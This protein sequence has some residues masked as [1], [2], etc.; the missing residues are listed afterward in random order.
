MRLHY[1]VIVRRSETRGSLLGLLGVLAFSLTLPATRAAVADLDGTIVGLGRALVAG[2]LA[3]MLLAIK[4][5]PFPARRQVRS[6]L[7]VAL[8]VVV[9]FPLLSALA[10]V[11]VPSTHGAIFV[12]LLPLSTAIMAVVRG[13]ERPTPAFWAVALVGIAIVVAFGISIGGGQLQAADLLLLGAIVAAGIGYAEG[14]RLAREMGGWRVVSWALVLAAPALVVPVGLA[15]REHGLDAAAP[16]WIGFAYVSGV[17]MFLA[18]FVWFQGLAEA[19]IARVGQ[20][21]LVQP[22]L[23]LGWAALL[24]GEQISMATLAAALGV[25]VTV[26]VGRRTRVE[27]QRTGRDA[28]RS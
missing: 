8:G 15:I 7:V 20:L 19:G 11:S 21:Q 16:A 3:A 22:I 5:E 2:A 17:S 4:R 12:G 23:T 28:S 10:L 9:G 26:A 25:I 24:L 6:L 14:G 18:F 1:N 27:S 13:G